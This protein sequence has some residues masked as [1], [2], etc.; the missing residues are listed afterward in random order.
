MSRELALEHFEDQRD[1]HRATGSALRSLDRLDQITYNDMMDARKAV[2]MSV[3][4]P[5]ESCKAAVGL[6]C[7]D[8]SSGAW[9]ALTKAHGMREDLSGV[10]GEYSRDLMLS[11]VGSA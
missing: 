11:R 8:R 3:T 9:L 7:R 10:N 6:P 5:A 2:V 4:C 1:R